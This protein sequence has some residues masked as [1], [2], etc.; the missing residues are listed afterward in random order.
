MNKYIVVKNPQTPFSQVVNDCETGFCFPVNKGDNLSTV[1]K[2]LCSYINNLRNDTGSVLTETDPIFLASSAYNIDDTDISNWNI[3]YSWGDHNGLYS[4]LNH[5]H[6]LSYLEESGASVG[7]VPQW[8][9]SEWVPVNIG[10]GPESDPVFLASDAAGISSTDISNWDTAY[11]WGDHSVV[12]YLTSES[13]PIFTAWLTT[14][15]NISTFTNDSGY[16]TTD[17]YTLD[18][19]LS[20]NRTVD[21][22][23]K[24]LLFDDFSRFR[25][26]NSRGQLE[27]SNTEFTITA[28]S[29]NLNLNFLLGAELLLDG[30]AGTAGQVLTAQGPGMAPYWTT[31]S[32]SVTPA[33][34][35]KTD[36]TNVT[37][38][39]GGTPSTALLQGVSLTLGWTGTLADGRIASASTW[40][41]KQ[42]ALSGTGI[43]KSTA[44]TISYL[45]DNSTN[46]DTAFGWGNHASAGYL[47]TISG[48]NISLLTNDSAFITASALSPY[49]TTASAALTYEPIFS[50]LPINK[51]GTNSNTALSNNRIIQSSGGAI[52]E[53]TAITASRALK[54]DANGIPVHFDIAT[55]PSLTELSYVKGV[56][57]DI[58][59][60]I[61]TKEDKSRAAYTFHANN[62][63]A[64]ANSTDITFKDIAEQTY[65]GSITWTGTTAPSGTTD[66]RYSW[67]QVGNLVTYDIAL[68]Y[69]TAGTSVTS[70]VFELPSD[71]PT[72]KVKTGLGGASSMLYRVIGSITISISIVTNGSVGML[73]RNSANTANEIYLATSSGNYKVVLAQGHYHTA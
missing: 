51:G 26:L 58:Q 66:F 35:T 1:I 19:T 11:S 6:T 55:E 56:T 69:G 12:G 5:T 47:T 9:G 49:L 22:N 63:N 7:D 30:I 57:S 34:L 36:D 4:L 23:N 48:L 67:T 54:S 17:F 13:D 73:R 44:G 33:A 39:L 59:T 71:M 37:L 14:S 25:L 3:A 2:K 68:V 65:S 18:G 27:I 16:L 38:T 53:A 28:D 40:N 43:V 21:C 72:P 42:A 15:P 64:T 62:T 45:T 41:A 8:N 31:P 61:G 24:E 60:Q 50:V 46:W 70:L 32:G 29:V 10:G 52:V 20:S